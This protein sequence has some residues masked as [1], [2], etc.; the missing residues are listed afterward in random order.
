MCFSFYDPKQSKLQILPFK[1]LLG[2]SQFLKA[3]FY[4]P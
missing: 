1:E 2:L 3:E 4:Q